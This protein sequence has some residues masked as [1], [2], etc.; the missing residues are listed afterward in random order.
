MDENDIEEKKKGALEILEDSRKGKELKPVDHK[1]I[2]YLPFRK[3]LYIVPRALSKL[4]EL[5]LNEKRVCTC[6][7]CLFVCVFLF[8][9]LFIYVCMRT[10][11]YVHICIYICIYILMYHYLHLLPFYLYNLPI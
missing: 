8:M 5:E 3:N 4:S 11:T 10:R 6:V 7:M 1:T 9:Y 2:E